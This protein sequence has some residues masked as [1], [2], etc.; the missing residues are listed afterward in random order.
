MRVGGQAGGRGREGYDNIMIEIRPSDSR[1]CRAL[2][3]TSTIRALGVVD[4]KVDCVP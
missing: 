4:Y 3:C 2:Y 1:F